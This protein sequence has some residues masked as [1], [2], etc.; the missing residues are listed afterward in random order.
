[1]V[2]GR[3]GLTKVRYWN[4]NPDRRVEYSNDDQYAEHFLD[5]FKEAV[6]CRL[7]SNGPVGA[8]L[9]SGLDSSSVVS[10]AQSL[11]EQRTV[12][13]SKFEMFSQVFPGLECDESTY[14]HDVIK[15]GI[16][17]QI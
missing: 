9:S 11:L 3:N 4:I 13:L 6:L 10:V 7:R 5:I 12:K 1:M 14:I 17:S 8:E 16:F 15:N 2:V